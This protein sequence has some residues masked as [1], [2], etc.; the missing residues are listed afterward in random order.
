M[1]VFL[2]LLAGVGIGIPI[3]WLLNRV[4]GARTTARPARRDPW[5]TWTCDEYAKPLWRRQS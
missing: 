5:D 1:I 3:G 4:R 2:E